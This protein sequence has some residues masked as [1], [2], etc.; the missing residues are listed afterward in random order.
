MS[1]RRQIPFKVDVAGIIQI[2]GI[3]LYSRPEA[4]F[5][6]LIQNAHDAIVRRRRRDL[7]YKGRI[8][9][10]LNP[11]GG[12]IEVK[13]DGIGLNAAEAEQYLGT[14]GIGVTGILKE[15]HPSAPQSGGTS[16]EGLIGQFGIG[17]FSAF[18]L[19]DE[20]VVESCRADEREGVRWSAGSGT[21]IEL[22]SSPRAETGTS[23]LMKLKPQFRSLVNSREG[24]EQIV[25][26]FADFLTVPI[27]VNRSEVR[28]NLMHPAWFDPTVD[29]ESL[30]MELET[31]FSE[32]PLDVFSIRIQKPIELIGAL[33]VTPQRTPG[34]SGV[35]V[36]TATVRR[37]VIS[38]RIQDLLPEWG[39]FLRG[40]IEFPNGTPTASREDLVRDETF[41]LAKQK[42]DELLRE[43]F[44]KL[45]IEEPE[46]MEAVLAWH[47]YSWAGAAL[48]DSNLRG[49]LRSTYRFNT[50]QGRKTFDEILQKSVSDPLFEPE[51]EHVIWHQSDRRQ[52]RWMNELFSKYSV[53]CVH[54]VRS[55]EESL[56]AAFCGDCQGGVDLR[57][58]SPSVQGFARDVL[59]IRD[60]EEAPEDW[61][62]FLDITGAKG[63]TARFRE[64][65]PVMAFLNERHEML[66]TFEDLKRQGTVPEGFQRLIDHYFQSGEQSR[67]EV[68]LNL[69]H[70]LVRQA[71]TESTASPL[72]GILRLLAVNALSGAGAS[73]PQAALTQQSDDLAWIAE[74]MKSRSR[75]SR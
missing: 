12:E 9:I 69:N 34:F 14:L 29:Q 56:L 33:Y 72:A 17:L 65:L 73:I 48:S 51:F 45:A 50:S 67:N 74:T 15:T 7:S 39:T 41:V 54:T 21:E 16:G 57:S 10:L 59:G 6:E 47:R 38:N 66:A 2:M 25:K 55:F 46:R 36:V 71:L 13:D 20:L 32:T 53:P 23:V 3:S 11:E 5:R 18:M 40:V 31:Y 27:Y 19:A 61:Q 30:T 44:Q 35:P 1:W 37:M 43:H 70:S 52:E 42:L 58:A 63:H 64:D 24:I 62:T 60:L 26:E 4:A 68:I 28:T 22:S 8:D 49:F 75:P